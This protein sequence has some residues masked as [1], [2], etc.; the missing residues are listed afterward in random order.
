MTMTTDDYGTHRCY[1]DAGQLHRE[2]GPAIVYM[3]GRQFWYQNGKLHR[4]DGPAVV[5]TMWRTKEWWKHGK[6]IRK[7]NKK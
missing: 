4:E 1:N 6:F 7:E 2:D 3:D 5:D